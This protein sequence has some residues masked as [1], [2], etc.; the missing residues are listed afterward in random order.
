VSFDLLVRGDAVDVAIAG[1]QI[2]AVGPELEGAAADELQARGL[3]V[4]PGAVDAHVHFNEPGRAEWEGWAT[5]SAAAASGGT[6]AVVEMPLNAHPPTVDGAAFDAKVAAARA[7]SVVDFAL[8]GGL[9]GGS[10]DRLDAL[11]DRGV[12]GFKAFM[13]GSG[14]D[15]FP[16]VDDDALGAGMIRAAALG[17]PVAVHAERPTEL[18]PMRGGSWRDWVDSRPVRAEVAAIER[19]VELAAETGCALHV[20]HVSSAEGVDVVTAARTRG[21]DVTCETCP[22]YLAWVDADLQGLGTRAKCAPPLRDDATRAALRERWSGGAIDWLAS[23]HSPC[24]PAMKAG[25]FAAAWGGIAGAQTLL[26]SALEAGAEPEAFTAA[27]ARRLRL[28]GKGRLEPGADADLVLVE[29]VGHALAAGELFDRHRANPFA[30]HPFPARVA[31]VIRRGE[32]IFSAGRLVATGGGRLLA[33]DRST[34]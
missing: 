20:V 1:E 21:V 33:P 3:L 32:T 28:A 34:T 9:V 29:P 19:A 18:R 30:G 2:A 26:V 25:D 10:L 14:I 11:A 8:W 31:R 17:L 13:C 27:P 16:A 23:D 12:V 4:L 22:H 6:T 5:G 15:D 7:A 24:P